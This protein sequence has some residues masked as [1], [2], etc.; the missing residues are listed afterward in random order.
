MLTGGVDLL[1]E[2]T[3]AGF[4]AVGAICPAPC[5]PFSVP[6]G[7]SVGEGTGLVVLERLDDAARRGSAPS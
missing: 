1:I 6:V 7:M 4:H 3:F 5:A 2:E